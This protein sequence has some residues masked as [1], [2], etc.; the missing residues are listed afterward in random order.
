MNNSRRLIM[1]VNTV[2][3]L[4]TIALDGG[5][6][7]K[8]EYAY[9]LPVFD[10]LYGPA[11]VFVREENEEEVAICRVHT[12]NNRFVT[13]ESITPAKLEELKIESREYLEEIMEENEAL[14]D[15]VEE[16]FVGKLM[17][18]FSGQAVEQKEFDIMFN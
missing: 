3:N 11:V 8:R 2:K 4:A 5:A 10:P 13:D 7:L 9:F 6:V 1:K 12:D 15:Q 16:T 18:D 14:S 17:E